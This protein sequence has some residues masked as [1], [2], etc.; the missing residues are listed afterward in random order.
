MHFDVTSLMCLHL[1][2]QA[3]A[4]YDIDM[5]LGLRVLVRTL[6]PVSAPLFSRSFSV[7]SA[8][9]AKGDYVRLREE[10]PV[11]YRQLLDG[12]LE[13]KRIWRQKPE[14]VAK[15]REFMKFYDMARSGDERR[16]FYRRMLNWGMRYPWFR[17][18]LPW[19][20]HQPVH[21]AKDVEHHCE[22]CNW[23]EKGGKRFWWRK[24]EQPSTTD[25]DSWLCTSCFV[26][27]TDWQEVMPKGYEDLTTIKEV[28]KRRDEL[29]HGACSSPQQTTRGG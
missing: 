21:Y 26:P 4:T 5:S 23:I 7:C 3:G 12:R 13:S 28:A 9:Q 15:Q 10:D 6:E 1:S 14:N 11:A 20:S 8:A 19:K 16:R 27:K 25:A 18:N 22:G 2:S 17:E 24:I 29:G